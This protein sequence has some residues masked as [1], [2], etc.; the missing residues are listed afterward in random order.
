M[1]VYQLKWI[2][3]LKALGW[4][5]DCRI[6]DSFKKKKSAGNQSLTESSGEGGGQREMWERLVYVYTAKEAECFRGKIQRQTQGGRK[7]DML[8]VR[9]KGWDREKCSRMHGW[10]WVLS[11]ECLY[12]LVLILS[13]ILQCCHA[14]A[15][16]T[17]SDNGKNSIKLINWISS[18]FISTSACVRSP[19]KTLHQQLFLS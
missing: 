10:R 15:L 7:R 5:T 13:S 6:S 16:L 8:K 1:K 2:I 9:Q 18:L 19:L 3:K 4:P 14:P 11:G 12:L 17:S